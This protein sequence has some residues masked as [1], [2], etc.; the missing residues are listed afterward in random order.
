ML[1]VMLLLLLGS[2][3]LITYNLLPLPRER[4]QLMMMEKKLRCEVEELRGQLKRH[5][6]A[7]R[8]GD[9]R[10]VADEEVA[11]RVAT[12]ENAIAQLQKSV[13]SSK[14]DEEALLSEMEVTGQAFED[15]QEQNNRLMAQLREKDDANF[16]LMSDRIKATQIQKMLKDEHALLTEQV[17]ALGVSDIAVL[18]IF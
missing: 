15:M 6:E 1:A 2:F 12:F 13:A 18:S 16:K 11:R 5:Q 3:G 14:Q 9:R 8:R 7:E 4:A 10:K 17:F